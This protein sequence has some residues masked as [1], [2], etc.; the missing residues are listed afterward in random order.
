MSFHI[1]G[2]ENTGPWFTL[3]F[4]KY[5]KKRDYP[6]QPLYWQQTSQQMVRIH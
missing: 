6:S 2:C 3:C 5:S 4:Y 1:Q